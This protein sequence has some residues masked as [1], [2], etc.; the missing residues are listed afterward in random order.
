[1][2]QT[3]TG[4]TIPLPAAAARDPYDTVVALELAAK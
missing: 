2:Q 4:L 3:A 1:V